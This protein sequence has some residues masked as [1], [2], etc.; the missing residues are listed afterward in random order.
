[1]N[2]LCQYLCLLVYLTARWATA[3]RPYVNDK[4]VR[5]EP[6][7][8]EHMTYIRALEESGNL[9]F[10]TEV[11]S[12]NHPV[13]VHIAAKD[14]DQ[15]VSEFKQYSLPYQVLVDDIQV[16][17]DE[18]Q[19]A[20]AE[21]LL[22]RQLKSRLFGQARADIVGT[23]ASYGEM[24]TYMQEK[25]SADPSR[26]RM[27]NIGS[28]SQGRTINAIEL[29][30]NPASTRNIWIDCGIHARGK[31][32]VP[33]RRYKMVDRKFLLFLIRMDYTCRMY[34]DCGQTDC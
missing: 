24:V 27:L 13:D 14:F 20:L 3:E 19:D 21:D 4:L 15:Y 5:L 22:V 28:T 29:A 11:V 32:F 6:L 18:E 30:Y 10:W 7:T 16:K 23:Y 2:R 34:L 8:D 33:R 1:M 31:Q 25:A 12:P 17:I 26:V 9:D